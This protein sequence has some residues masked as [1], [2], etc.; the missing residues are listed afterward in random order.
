VNRNYSSVAA[1]AR[2]RCEY[3]QAPEAVFNFP[4]EVEHIVPRQSGLAQEANL[5]LACRSCNL[6]KADS[7]HGVDPQTNR[8]VR[9][10]HPRVDRWDEH[11]YPNASGELQGRT[12][13]GRATI[14]QLRMNAPAQVAARLLWVRLG[15][16]PA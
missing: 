8:A 12:E 6:F 3:C 5:A 9:L 10:Y 16:Y 7:T 13:I 1:R 4:F 14:A 2:H 15:I 11:F